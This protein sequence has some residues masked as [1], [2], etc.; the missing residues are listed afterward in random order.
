MKRSYRTQPHLAKSASEELV[1]YLEELCRRRISEVFQAVL[2]AEVDEIL[3]RR[4]YERRGGA[5]DGYRD[6]HDRP[7]T[8]TSNRGSFDIARPRVRGVAFESTA[9]P[10][11]KRR[12]E[13]V[14]KSLAELWIDGL[15]TRD[16]EGTLRAFLGA[17]APLSAATI[18]RTN[19]RL[20]A[21]LEAWNTRRLDD[22][23]LIFSWAD[24]MHLGTGPDDERRVFLVVVGGDRLGNKH[25]L[26]LREAMSE[27]EAGWEELFADLAAR[28]LRAP[29]LL[30][31]DGACGLWA[32]AQK[33]WPAAAQQRCWI[34]KMRNVE[35]KLPEK[36]RAAAHKAMSEIMYAESEPEA[37]HKLDRLA[38]SYE[39]NYPK[40][41]ACLRADRE[42]MF[43]FHRFPPATWI[44]L[45][46]TNPIESLFSPIR[47]RTDAMNRLRT[48]R[49]ATA[50]LYAL[51]CKLAKSWR[52]LHGYR[53]LIDIA[54]ER[55][56]ALKRAA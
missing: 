54:P 3:E 42:R 44:H 27:S 20:L 26:A 8:I 47:R 30:V 48:G 43:A 40:A 7:R 33:A 23:D 2:E 31:A 32:A 50:V 53:D 55:P 49:F 29:Q 6:G 12:L 24:G 15:A 25:L 17:E 14:D 10:K 41:A 45:R 19:R 18:T 35:D 5:G 39:R 37:R 9:L 51:T 11:H 21:E 13:N 16:F 4:R 36:Q 28:G 1:S 56:L 22:L 38:K 52:R 34:H 46:T